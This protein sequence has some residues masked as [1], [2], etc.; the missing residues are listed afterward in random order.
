NGINVAIN[1]SKD[2]IILLIRTNS[3]VSVTAALALFFRPWGR[4]GRRLAVGDC[5]FLAVA[6]ALLA[7]FSASLRTI[8][9]TRSGT[10]RRS[11]TM[12]RERAKTYTDGTGWL[13][14][15]AKKRATT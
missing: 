5:C 12:T 8:C 4:P 14:R 2:S 13:E 6:L 7:A 1:C 10:A 15:R 9:S 11:G 3:G